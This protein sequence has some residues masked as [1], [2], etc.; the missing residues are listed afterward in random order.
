M[1]DVVFGKYG[2]LF[3][4]VDTPVCYLRNFLF[5]GLPYFSIGMLLKKADN[6]LNLNK[7]MLLGG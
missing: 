7:L 6:R 1:V 4:G 3:L 2:I 5:V